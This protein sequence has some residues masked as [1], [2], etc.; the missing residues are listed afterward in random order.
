MRPA[1]GLVVL[2]LAGASLTYAHALESE[3]RTRPTKLDALTYAD[4]AHEV[5]SLIE[6][7][8]RYDADARYWMILGHCYFMGGTITGAGYAFRQALYIDPN[9]GLQSWTPLQPQ[10]D[11]HELSVGAS[12]LTPTCAKRNSRLPPK[13]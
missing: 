7:D 5:L 11:L 13:L 9:Q 6:S 1:K 2:V 4:C 3:P 10:S 8:A 12:A